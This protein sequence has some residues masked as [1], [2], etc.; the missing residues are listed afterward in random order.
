MYQFREILELLMTF[1]QS[2]TDKKDN[3]K[4]SQRQVIYQEVQMPAD[5]PS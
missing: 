2:S 3:N 5:S 4:S 1:L